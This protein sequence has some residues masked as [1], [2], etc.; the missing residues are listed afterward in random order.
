MISVILDWL[1]EPG[2]VHRRCQQPW[3]GSWFGKGVRME[4]TSR[5]RQG[6]DQVT[7]GRKDDE[8]CEWLSVSRIDPF[9]SSESFSAFQDHKLAPIPPHLL[10]DLFWVILSKI[11]RH[12]LKTTLFS[13]S[14]LSLC[15][16][17]GGYWS[18]SLIIKTGKGSSFYDEVVG[19]TSFGFRQ[20]WRW[21]RLYFSLALS[22]WTN[23]LLI[24]NFL[25][26]SKKN[27]S[28]AL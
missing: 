27:Q 2:R 10:L 7:K 24:L 17:L 13:A 23:C 6:W 12:L 15:C 5:K 4:P 3:E 26:C 25:T 11:C 19:I 21:L 16:S 8:T 14:V 18:L 9:W 22:P 1:F 20:S 28:N